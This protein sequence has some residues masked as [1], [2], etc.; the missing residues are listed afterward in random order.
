LKIIESK[1]FKDELRAITFYIKKDKLSASIQFVT[2]LKKQIKNLKEFPY[3][4]KKS[5]YFD[6]DAIRDMVY[7]G[8]T[9]VYEV[10]KEQ[11]TLEIM[12]IFNQNL[13]DL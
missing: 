10:N 13:P 6:N 1:Q 2:N 5:T 4:Y 11:S 9:I 12:S 3:Q 7:M 8:Y